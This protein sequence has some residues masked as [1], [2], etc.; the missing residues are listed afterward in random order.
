MGARRTEHIAIIGAGPCGLACARELERLGF[1]DW[2]IYERNGWPGGHASSVVDGQGFT[3]DLGGHVVFSHFG[4]FDALLDEAMGDEVLRARALVVR[5]RRRRLG[6]VSVPE[7]PPLS[8]ARGRR[9]VPRRP[10]GR[11][12]RQRRHGLR[13]LDGGHVRRGHHAS[14]HAPVQPQGLGDAARGDVGDLDRGARQRRRLRPGAGERDGRARRQAAGARTTR[15]SFRARAAPARSTA[16][17]PSA[18]AGA[19]ASTAS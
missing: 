3:W 7:Q 16:G 17:S 10:R 6:A 9:G 18:S 5:P 11:R 8:R 2:A 15:S 14:L 12:R 4:E 19:S 1:R 13:D